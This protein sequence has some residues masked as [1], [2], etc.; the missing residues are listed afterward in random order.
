MFVNT[1]NAEQAVQPRSCTLQAVS[2]MRI[3]FSLAL[4]FC[5]LSSACYAQVKPSIDRIVGIVG[6]HVILQSDVNQMYMEYVQQDPN[7]SDTIVCSIMQNLLSRDL[8]CEQ[9]E[10]DSVTVAD[11]EVEG[12]L[13][14]RVRY[15]VQQYGSEERM[16]QVIGKSLVQIK[17]EYRRLFKDQLLSQ[18]MQSQVIANVKVSPTEV[19]TFFDKIPKDSLPMYPSMVEV[20]Q[21]VLTPVANKE[22]EAY[23]REQLED[24]REQI[25]SGKMDFET[26]AGIISEDGSKDQGG[27]L[28]KVTR[29][30][31]VP[32]FTSAAF[33]LQN[34]EISPVIR[35]RFGF[36]I[37]QMVQRLGENA[38]LRHILIKPKITTSDLTVTSTKADSI[39]QLIQS[40]KI[41]YVDA[42][43][44]F[45]SDDATK[46][47]GG[48]FTNQSTG[49]S[50]VNIDEL[51]PDVALQIGKMKPGEYSAPQIFTDL[52]T[53]D[54][55]VRIIY[56]KNITEPHVANLREDY[57]KIQ[58]AALI[59]KQNKFLQ[60]WLGE[61]I[62]Q[63]Y[64]YVH[65]DYILCDSLSDWAKSSTK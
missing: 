15:F 2:V 18:R 10:R 36:H 12:N 21:I 5:A 52:R 57:A 16:E 56:L 58:E 59:E 46:N 20:G 3:V 7:I 51:E 26:A 63:F 30:Q 41:S 14:N 39:L 62:A 61:R 53:G 43:A 44:K 54:R 47:S 32:E 22:V 8:L 17:D 34:G 31:M 60:V 50:L 1:Q 27:D 13:D 29:D 28:G 65:P 33:R 35:T 55:L 38:R 48:M 24:T 23:A 49:S 9:A 40:K 4:A 11:E 42:V 19:R 64:I 25:V 45:S 37:I 6:D